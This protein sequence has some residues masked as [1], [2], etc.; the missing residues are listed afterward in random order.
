LLNPIKRHIGKA[1]RMLSIQ[2]IDNSIEEIK[3]RLPLSFFSQFSV[4]TFIG[5]INSYS[6][7]A[8]YNSI[9]FDLINYLHR[10]RKSYGKKILSLYLRLITVYLMKDTFL[11]L[12]DRKITLEIK[13][14]IIQWFKDILHDLFILSDDYYSINN[15]TFLKDLAVCRL[16][17]YPVGGP[18]ISQIC[19]IRYSLFL[20][21][22]FN[23]FIKFIFLYAVHMR[24]FYPFYDLHTSDRYIHQFNKK[25]RNKCYANVGKLLKLNLHIK[26]LLGESWFNDPHLQEI[27]HRLS[28]LYKIPNNNGAMVFRSGTSKE[29]IIQATLK[30]KTRLKL[31]N[32]GK[33]MPTSYIFIWPRLKL[34]KWTEAVSP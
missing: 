9:D 34:I 19:R 15:E 24:G 21:G 25:N 20:S 13:K 1:V 31:Y 22:S 16:K 29:D 23:Q 5:V 3:K 7:K 27:S 28:Y 17:A 30:S 4:D 12:E 2:N 11:S 10:I 6:L 32:E 14:N 33:Y 8:S 26:G 18:W